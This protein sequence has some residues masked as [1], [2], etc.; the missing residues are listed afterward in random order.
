MGRQQVM[1][2]FE[3]WVVV[4]HDGGERV[5]AYRHQCEFIEV[6]AHHK[7]EVAPHALAIVAYAMDEDAPDATDIKDRLAV[8]ITDHEGPRL[9]EY[10]DFG[11]PVLQFRR[12][13]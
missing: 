7:D 4:G 6:L 3:V 9:F 5:G 11:G 13:P 10:T 8:L 1:L 12:V 2:K